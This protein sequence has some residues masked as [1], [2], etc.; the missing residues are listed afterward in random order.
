MNDW[1]VFSN[2]GLVLICIA[3]QPGLRLREIAECVG[4]TERA[5]SRIVGELCDRGYINRTREGRR[6]HYEI[7]SSQPLGQS[8][9]DGAT[10]GEMLAPFSKSA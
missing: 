4:V 5:A 1:D 9:T 8:L 6:N 3:R 10:V 2:H 7:D